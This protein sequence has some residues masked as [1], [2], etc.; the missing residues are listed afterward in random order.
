MNFLAG[1]L[2]LIIV[3]GTVGMYKGIVWIFFTTNK[4]NEK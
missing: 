1:V 3:A 4:K 2:L